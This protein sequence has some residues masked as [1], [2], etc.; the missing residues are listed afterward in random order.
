MV[1]ELADEHSRS[2]MKLAH[3]LVNVCILILVGM[4]VFLSY[5]TNII[6]SQ[7]ADE[8]NLALERCLL[9]NPSFTE[10]VIVDETEICIG[11]FK[12]TTYGIPL[13]LLIE[14]MKPS[15]SQ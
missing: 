2:K 3:L 12:G 7:K 8:V 4:L 6:E 11:T 14:E 5:Q 10:A 1:V 9:L 15:E 13:D